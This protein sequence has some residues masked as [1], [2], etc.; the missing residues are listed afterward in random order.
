MRILPSIIALAAAMQ[1]C[2]CGES[3]PLDLESG[4]AHAIVTAGGDQLHPYISGDWLVWFDLR[5]DPDG[6]CFLPS[7]SPDGQYDDSCD[8]RVRS[9][10]LV[11]GESHVLSDVI[12]YEVRP[13]ASEGFA[14]WRCQSDLGPGMCVTPIDRKQVSF[15][16]GVGYSNYYYSGD[17]RP[18]VNEGHVAWAVYEY[19]PAMTIYKIKRADLGSGLVEDLMR[20]DD[21][22]TEFAYFG[23]LMAWT[24]YRWDNGVYRYRL[25]LSD[26]HTGAST[27]V[28]DGQDPAYGLGGYGGLLAFKQGSP[29]YDGGD[30]GGVHVFYRRADGQVRRA[31]SS[32]ARVSEEGPLSVGDDLLVWLDHRDGDYQV[33]ARDLR[34]G[35][36][37]IVSPPEALIGAYMPPAVGSQGIV[38]PDMRDGDFDLYIYRF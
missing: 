30:D 7:Y 28:V 13:V 20:L 22:P 33:V 4:K 25:E 6:F 17:Q 3:A 31:D 18:W 14:A 32:A 38:W 19:Y 11:T 36:E 15:Y 5:D 34:G 27:L 12:G 35:G 1:L 24:G 37:T 16:S 21:Y 23:Q 8:G 10:N 2:A 29:D 26:P 9:M